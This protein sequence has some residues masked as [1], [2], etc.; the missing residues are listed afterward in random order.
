MRAF[1]SI[2]TVTLLAVFLQMT[3][4]SRINLL[5]GSADL[6]LTLL[7][8]MSL[9]ERARHMLPLGAAAGL[10][11][12]GISAA[13]WYIC[14]GAYLAAVGLG[15][16]LARRIWQAPLL[17]LLVVTMAGTLVL[18]GST[19]V[20]RALFET[21]LFPAEVFTQIALPSLFLNFL[22]AIVLHPLVLDLSDRLYPLEA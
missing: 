19:F 12:G 2:L 1:L 8:A 6:V 14:V 16:L 20:Y 18:H 11:I 7:A 21:A 15:R 9:Q 4:V 3:V 13:P 22:I 17:A 5:S 10:L